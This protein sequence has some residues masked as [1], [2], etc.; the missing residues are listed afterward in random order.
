MRFAMAMALAAFAERKHLVAVARPVV[1]K[2]ER[3]AAARQ[4]AAGR[5]EK[6][7]KAEKAETAEAAQVRA[8]PCSPAIRETSQC[9]RDPTGAAQPS[10][11]DSARC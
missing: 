1:V 11:P 2:V 7:E 6:A 8:A 9:R 10:W 4:P 3:L 5:S